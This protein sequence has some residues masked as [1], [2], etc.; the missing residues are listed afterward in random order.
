MQN[1]KSAFPISLFLPKMITMLLDRIMEND[2]EN[3][4]CEEMAKL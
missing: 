3:D 4:K 2:D 1:K